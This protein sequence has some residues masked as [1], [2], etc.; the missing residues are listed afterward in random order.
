MYDS[1]SSFV[2]S[3][4]ACILYEGV[5]AFCPDGASVQILHHVVMS[6]AY[7]YVYTHA[8]AAMPTTQRTND[9]NTPSIA[10]TNG[11][12]FGDLLSSRMREGSFHE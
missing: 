8:S 7:I 9:Y 1:I 4:L 5:W 3:V 2:H 6:C 12:T 10:L 11:S